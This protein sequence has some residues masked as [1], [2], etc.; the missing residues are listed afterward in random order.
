MSLEEIKSTL[1]SGNPVPAFT[2]HQQQQRNAQN[3]AEYQARENQ[4]I[5]AK[6]RQ[7]GKQDKEAM[8]ASLRDFSRTFKVKKKN[9]FFFYF[10]PK[11]K[12]CP[13]YYFSVATLSLASK[14]LRRS[15]GM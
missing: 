2:Q 1:L 6:R 9:H 14:S 12:A 10:S 7:V 5:A 8:V 11:K 15:K 3:F 13:D 4:S